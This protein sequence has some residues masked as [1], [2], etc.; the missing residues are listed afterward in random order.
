MVTYGIPTNSKFS[1]LR[2]K[3]NVRHMSTCTESACIYALF[4]IT[5]NFWTHLWP[6][7]SN[8]TPDFSLELKNRVWFVGVYLGFHEP[9]QEEITRCK[10][11]RSW[12][13]I[14]YRHARISPVP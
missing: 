3:H 4:E 1:R 7:V 10:I 2:M 6:D 5:N 12:W 8:H 13:A 11:T 9:P 14:P